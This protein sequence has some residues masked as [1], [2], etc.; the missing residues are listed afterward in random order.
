MR[1]AGSLTPLV[2][3][4]A[5]ASCITGASSEERVSPGSFLGVML[6]VT[7]SKTAAGM[8]VAPWEAG[9]TGDP[10]APVARPWKGIPR[11]CAAPCTSCRHPVV[12]PP[13]A[14]RLCRESRQ[15]EVT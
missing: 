10:P 9:R 7:T 13:L 6:S 8:T 2:S 3:C 4:T 15:E 5:G 12:L 1:A 11:R 14:R